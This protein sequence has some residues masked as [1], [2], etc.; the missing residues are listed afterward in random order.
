MNQFIMLGCLWLGACATAFSQQQTNGVNYQLGPIPSAHKPLAENSVPMGNIQTF[1]EVKLDL[2]ITSGPYEPTW[3]SIEA[4]YPGTPEWLRDS[5]FGIWIH[6][7]PQSAGESGD[8]YARKMYVE[9]T[10]AYE[11]HLKN[12]GHPSEVGYKEVLR[13]WNPKKFNPQALV[14]IYKDAG[15]RFLII[16]GVHHDQ[17]DMWDS[18]YQPWNSTRLGP[19]RDL[20][21]EWEE[22]ARKA[23]IRFGLTFHH[24]YSWWWW[25]TAFQSDTKGD[26]KGVPYDGNL[27]LADGKG[28][29]WE[30]LD[31]KYLYGI[32]LREYETVA[33]AANSRWSPPQAGIFSGHLEYAEWYAKWW[34]LRMMDA[35]DKYNPDFIYTDGTDQQPFSGS[36]TGTGYKCDAMQR[37]IADFYNKTLDRRGKVDVFSIVKFRKQTNGTVNTCETG[38]PENIKTDQA[39]IAETPVGDWFYGPNFVYSSDAVIRYL[40]E[41]VAR[42]GAVGV[43]IPLRP[44]GSLDEGCVKML[45]EVGEWMRINGQGIYGSSAWSVLG[46]GK[47]GKLNVL[48]GGFIGANQANHSFYT[49]DFRFTVGK[50]GVIYAWC[51]TV[52]KAGDKLKIVSL[53]SDTGLGQ[54]QVT[55]VELLGEKNKIEW[56]QE[57]DGLSI[58]YPDSAHLK[59]AVGFRIVCK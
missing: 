58:V 40:L 48:P 59:T 42:D 28:K 13:D 24:E 15:A 38:I 22:A 7:G 8:W 35:V 16:Q 41:I 37:V 3:K 32:N 44:D 29:W 54:K 27:T 17:F 23:G 56:K 1:E 5:K 11:N 10:P 46:E 2:P 9:G 53:G 6:F 55:S 31:P 39:W 52:P 47:D 43:S 50:D 45:K 19:K 49:T 33:E 20:I 57:A 25:Q 36:G 21:G 14:D 4:N 26:K 12:Y 18:K 30:G 51:M 34:A